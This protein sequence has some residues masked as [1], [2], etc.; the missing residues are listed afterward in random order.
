VRTVQGAHIF[1]LVARPLIQFIQ[2][3]C[4]PIYLTGRVLYHLLSAVSRDL[5]L[6]RC[7]LCSICRSLSLLGLHLCLLCF[8]NRLPGLVFRPA[9]S[10]QP[11]YN[12]QYERGGG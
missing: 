8:Q 12:G 7:C 1:S 2:M 10:R 4:D 6:P 5:S 9:T 3:F 11:V